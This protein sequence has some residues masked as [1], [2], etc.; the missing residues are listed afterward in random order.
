MNRLFRMRRANTKSKPT[1]YDVLFPQGITSNVI[2]AENGGV[3][4]SFLIQY[5]RHLG[6]RTQHFNSAISTGTNRYLEVR[7]KN[8]VL[9]DTYPLLLTLHTSLECEPYLKFNDGEFKEIISASGDRIPGGQAEGTTIFLVWNANLDKWILMSADN[10]SD[11]TKIVLPVQKEYNYTALTDNEEVIVI[12]GFNKKSDKLS[13]NYGQTILRY[14]LDYEYI[15]SA[16][17]AIHLIGFGLSKGDVL[18]C[19][20]TNFITTAKR[21]HFRYELKSSDFIVPAT[22]DNQTIF[23][24][25]LEAEGAHSMVVNYNQTILRNNIDYD[26]DQVTH[27]VILKEFALQKDEELVFT[28]TQFMEAPGELVPN[29]WGAT[30]NYRYKLNV[31]HGSYV[32]T[33]D[34]V[35]VFP[36][37]EFNYK[38]DDIA[39]ID[40]NHLLI[41]DVD[42]TIDEIGNVVLLKK[43]LNTDDEI[44]FTILQGAMVDVP[45]F[46]VI[47]AS[48][49]DGQHILVDM[50]YSVLSNYYCLLIKLKHTLLSAPT[51]KCVDG[52]AE[53]I[54]DCFHTPVPGGYRAGS[55]LWLVYD[56][57][58]HLWYSLSHSQVDIT[59]FVPN[60]IHNN[61]YGNF[62]GYH[63]DQG[64]T[65][66]KETVIPHELGVKPERIEVVPCEPPTI[67][68][69][70]TITE[71][72]DIWSYADETNIYVG[73]SGR[74]ISKFKWSATTEDY[75]NDLRSYIDQE[76]DKVRTN[77]GKVETILSTFTAESDGV[78]NI[79]NIKQ[80]NPRVDK[81]MVNFG[82][83]LLRE[84]I[85]Y[86]INMINS[87]IDLKTFKL[88]TDDV[89]QFV[90]IKQ[91]E[92]I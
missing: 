55:Y 27:Q 48:G 41:Y 14:G 50:S 12:P 8:E 63:P 43:V 36:V 79:A 80:Y 19:I 92:F 35:S 88:N 83:T 49:Q 40:D 82:Q 20:I 7:M 81:L 65:G 15:K 73:N 6:D 34:N 71:I 54:C 18:H 39:L 64:D 5:D 24:I 28:I 66:F 91:K 4:E 69:D 3:L 67:L 70:G 37:P 52:P 56:E 90:V 58:E 46:N 45:N 44:F 26:I 30:G 47:K 9:V 84:G 77:P 78:W 51:L 29:N 59:Q 31:I 85:D 11:I 57:E 2:R 86:D 53:P 21:G 33:E 25:P 38:R 75:T 23:N 62:S 1:D 22:E 32:A 74:S 68:E 61:G 10:F 42:Y 76:L 72:G 16:N 17:D 87:G 13:V 89:L 60:H